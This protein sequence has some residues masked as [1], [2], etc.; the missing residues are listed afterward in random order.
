MSEILNQFSLPVRA[1]FERSFKAPTQAQQLG[2]RPIVAGKSTLLLAPTGSGKTLAAFLSSL[3][4]LMCGPARDDGGLR[5]LYVSPLK[6]LA[7]DVER[8]LR[9]PIAGIR[10]T[11]A[12]LGVPVREPEVAVRSGDTPAKERSRFQ[13]AGGDLLITTPESLYL[14]LTSQAARH[15]ATLETV[16]IDEIHA[17]LPTK[18]G[19]HLFMSL[20]RLELLRQ[21]QPALQ[22]IG[23]SATQRPLDEAAQLL[24]GGRSTPNR[25]FE[26]ARWRWWMHAWRRACTWR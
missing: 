8:N 14:M 23:L 17:L 20:E 21:G 13:R 1:W 11:A 15:F 7:I 25:A 18:R 26:R 9:A 16:I 10:A 22:R 12:E 24:G 3:D 4:K 6:A 2:W 19:A 5:V